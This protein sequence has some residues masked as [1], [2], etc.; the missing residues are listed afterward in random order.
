MTMVH[1]EGAR[2]G[3]GRPRRKKHSLLALP[4]LLF[5]SGIV[6]ALIVIAWLLWPRWPAPNVPIDAP[7][8][9]I[10]IEDVTFNIPPGAI[11]LKAKRNPG[12][13]ERIDLVFMWPGLQPPEDRPMP[14][15]SS[16]G[17][18]RVFLTIAANDGTL[19]PLERFN[20]IYPRYL[21]SGTTTL[22]SGLSVRA[23]RTGTPYQGEEILYDRDS[24]ERFA[25][26]CTRD[27]HSAAIGMCL[28]QRRVGSA[29][30]TVRFPREWLKDW[31]SV[32]SGI[33]HLLASFRM[34]KR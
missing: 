21:E 15:V 14:M 1:A 9:P 7:S 29:D 2:R 22:E 4:V 10:T 19:P 17:I 24:P 12:T 23:F 33:E 32:L 5:I 28:Y 20:T 3:R 18:D 31:S 13:Q 11:R 16:H 8:V 26:R 34:S 6:L 25:V 27:G 30:I